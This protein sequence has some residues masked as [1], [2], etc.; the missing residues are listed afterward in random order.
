MVVN[1]QDTL[2][3]L[4]P[5]PNPN[6]NPNPSCPDVVLGD[7]HQCQGIPYNRWA[8]IKAQSPLVMS[9]AG[10]VLPNPSCHIMSNMMGDSIYGYGVVSKG[11]YGA[12][13][14]VEV[15]ASQVHP[16]GTTPFHSLDSPTIFGMFGGANGL[17]T[18]AR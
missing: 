15:L 16:G 1:G 13:A 9:A 7:V 5:N 18:K 11:K 2:I 8:R 10:R 3:Y 6:P 4:K 14:R 12:Y 17:M